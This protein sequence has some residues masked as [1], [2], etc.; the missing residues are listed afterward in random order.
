MYVMLF[1]LINCHIST[2]QNTKSEIKATKTTKLSMY[3]NVINLAFLLHKS[4][5]LKQ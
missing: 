2:L 1:K 3:S 4:S 5:Q